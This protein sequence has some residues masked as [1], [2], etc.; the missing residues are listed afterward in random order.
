MKDIT[1]TGTAR[2]ATIEQL[3]ETVIPAFLSPPPTKHTLRYWFKVANIPRFKANP[4]ARN[5]GGTAYYSVAAIEKLLRSRTLSPG[6]I[7]AQGRPAAKHSRVTPQ[8]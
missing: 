6:D 1:N 7:K 8:Q 4:L 3:L 2:L 5:G